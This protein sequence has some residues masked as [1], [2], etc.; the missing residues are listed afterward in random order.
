MQ[1]LNQKRSKILWLSILYT[2]LFFS[3]ILAFPHTTGSQSQ[4]EN[5]LYSAPIHQGN[6]TELPIIFIGMWN[7]QVWWSQA[8][9]E[10]TQNANTP[11]SIS[12][13]TNGSNWS[14]QFWNSAANTTTPKTTITCASLA[15]CD[16]IRLSDAYTTRQKAQYY[17]SIL[18]VLQW[19]QQVIGGNQRISNALFSITLDP[20]KWDRRWWG[21][22]KTITIY[23]KDIASQQEFREILTHELGHIIDLGV[24]LWT[25]TMLNNQFLLWDQ[26]KFSIDDPSL[27]F[28]RIS[29]NTNNTRSANASYTDFVWWYAMSSPYEDFSESFN[30]FLRHND[31]FKAMSQNSPALAQKYNYL[32]NLLKGFSFSNDI[33]NKNKVIQQTWR[34]PWDTT[35]MSLE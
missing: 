25:Q 4:H 7:G 20:T 1:A 33:K 15:V 35:R 3:I 29:W 19:I 17:T 13:G 2:L 23:T 14:S 34:R 18:S 21:G 22:S 31:A 9:S 24:I 30:A 11:T 27:N 5:P 26:A 10:Q 28:Y 32:Y 16:K 8:S 6:M 12:N